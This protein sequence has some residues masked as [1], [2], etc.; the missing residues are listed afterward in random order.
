MLAG[1]PSPRRSAE[2]NK[3]LIDRLIISKAQKYEHEN[4]NHFTK[5]R[6]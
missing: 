3:P 2:K 5:L 4:Y 1:R 6:E